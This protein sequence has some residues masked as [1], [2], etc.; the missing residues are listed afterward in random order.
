MNY[1]EAPW[2][3]YPR[4]DAQKEIVDARGARIALVMADVDAE[5]T[6]RLISAAPELLAVC[7]E[8]VAWWDARGIEGNADTD[9]ITDLARAAIKKAEGE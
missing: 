8:L 2:A 1:A 9:R 4:N 3:L 5:A 7:R 6:A